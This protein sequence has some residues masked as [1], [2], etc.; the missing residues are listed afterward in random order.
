M[1]SAGSLASLASVGQV[2]IPGFRVQ[3]VTLDSVEYQVSRASLASAVFQVLAVSRAYLVSVGRLDSLVTLDSQATA[4][5]LGFQDLVASQVSVD[6]V[7]CL[8]IQALRVYQD[9]LAIVDLADLVVSREALVTAVLRDILVS[10]DIRD[11]PDTLVIQVY[12]DSLA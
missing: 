7:E 8:V 4:G 2:V 9:S 11:H 5:S 3:V 12:Q 10:Q 1:V 6:I